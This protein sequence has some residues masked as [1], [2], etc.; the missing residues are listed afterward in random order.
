MAAA[1]IP[2]INCNNLSREREHLRQRF[3]QEPQ[4]RDPVT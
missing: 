1:N 3:P 4:L 2:G